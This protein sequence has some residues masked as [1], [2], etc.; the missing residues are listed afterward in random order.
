VQVSS[1]SAALRCDGVYNPYTPSG[2]LVV[3]DVQMSCHSDWIL[4]PWLAGTRFEQWIPDLYQAMFW[5]LRR[6]YDV[7]GPERVDAWFGAGNPARSNVKDQTK[8]FAG[9]AGATL[10]VAVV[11]SSVAAF[12]MAKTI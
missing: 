6:I 3:N 10:A 11:V 4:D 2:K 8:W 5:P 12:A 1:S 9:I 7:I